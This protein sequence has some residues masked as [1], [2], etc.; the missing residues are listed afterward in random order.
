MFKKTVFALLSTAFS[1]SAHAQE[2][3]RDGFIDRH[4][5]RGDPEP[6]FEVH[7]Q[8]ERRKQDARAGEEQLPMFFRLLPER[9]S[10]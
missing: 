8:R 4:I 2:D 5:Y 6:V 10:T 3:E 1:L 9:R 7:A